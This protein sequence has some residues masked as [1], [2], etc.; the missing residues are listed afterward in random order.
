LLCLEEIRVG[1][2]EQQKQQP[3]QEVEVEERRGRE[4]MIWRKRKTNNQTA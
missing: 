2:E 3:Q 1:E 4:R